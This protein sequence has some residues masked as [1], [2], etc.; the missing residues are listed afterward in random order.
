MHSFVEGNLFVIC[1]SMPTLRK[2]FK[3]FLPRL[4]GT[5]G[6]GSSYGAYGTGGGGTGG[7]AQRS[8]TISR[9]RNKSRNYA[10]F[11][12]D[13]NGSND[14]ISEEDAMEMERFSGDKK[15]GH[16]IAGA[17]VTV[18]A[19]S[20][21]DGGEAQRDDHSERAILQTKSFTVQYD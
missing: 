10:Q 21:A 9:M 5:S 7:N 6:Q 17:T 1:G 12:S 15:G 19:V 16:G 18:G 8:N 14:N 3:H 13:A 4:M 2:F 11:A 20:P